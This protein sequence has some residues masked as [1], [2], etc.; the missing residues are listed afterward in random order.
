[1]EMVS[2]DQIYNASGV[3]DMPIA[4]NAVVYSKAFKLDGGTKFG[5]TYK[6][7]STGADVIALKIELEQSHLLPTTEGAAD[8]NYVVPEGGMT[9]VAAAADKLVHIASL[10]PVVTRYARL[11][12]TGGGTNSA[13][14]TVNC[15]IS[16]VESHG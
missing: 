11:K 6:P 13:S 12:I 2:V 5:I 14:T 7:N 4:S 15:K 9:I 8:A 10:S 16:R 1:M 3:A